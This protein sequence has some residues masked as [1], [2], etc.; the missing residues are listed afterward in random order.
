M[1]LA[2]E[3]AFLDASISRIVSAIRT[4]L[5][6]APEGRRGLKDAPGGGNGVQTIRARFIHVLDDVTALLET[7]RA[8]F[9]D[10]SDATDFERGQTLSLVRGSMPILV[11]LQR[12]RYWI[13]REGPS[14]RVPPGV[15]TFFADASDGIL[16]RP[17]DV[18]AVAS[19]AYRYSAVLQPLLKQVR[20]GEKDRA[21][22]LGEV[23]VE[24]VEDPADVIPLVVTVP[25]QEASSIFLHVLAVHEIAHAAVGTSKLADEVEKRLPL[26][27]KESEAENKF[28]TSVI[29]AAAAGEADTDL[30]QRLIAENR[31]E[32]IRRQWLEELLCDAVAFAWVGPPYILAF[33]S[34]SLRWELGPSS[35]HPSTRDRIGMLLDHSDTLNWG[36]FMRSELGPV[37]DWL[38]TIKDRST[39]ATPEPFDYLGDYIRARSEAICAVAVE[40]LEDRVWTPDAL[41]L[42]LPE[43]RQLLRRRI[44]P[45]YA[46]ENFDSR[47][48]I[49]AGWLWRLAEPERVDDSVEEVPTKQDP[50]AQAPL[51]QDLRQFPLMRLAEAVDDIE[52]QNFLAKALELSGIVS[53][54]KKSTTVATT[55]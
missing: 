23:Y 9:G 45:V 55:A 49:T 7:S 54:W 16:H 27:D 29:R 37:H 33:A 8:K 22:A 28:I 14:A 15:L 24:P 18:L 36:E 26:T 12:M 11:A 19:S 35:T 44:L 17:A 25:L 4:A 41:N 42:E 1:D 3:F 51:E 50:T 30:A 13:T 34:F 5:E 43:I 39:G 32:S 46:E 2:D 48:V 31:L 40:S 53:A 10:S 21:E 20:Q 38:T 6:N 47:S 52:I